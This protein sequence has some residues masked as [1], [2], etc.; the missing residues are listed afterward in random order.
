VGTQTDLPCKHVAVQVSGCNECLSLALLSQGARDTACVQCDQVNDLLR[1]VV[2]LREEVERLRSIRDCENEID[3]WSHTLRQKQQ[4]EA[5]SE[6]DDPLPSC[7]QAEGGDLR[8]K[9]EWSQIPPWRGKRNPSQPPSPSQLP[10]HNRYGA[11][12]IEDNATE[13]G[14]DD[15]TSELPRASHSPPRLRTSSTKKGRKVIVVGDSLLKGTEG[16]ICRPDP[17]H[18]EVICLPGAR[19]KDTQR[20]LPSLVQTSDYYSLLIFQA[21][22]EEVGTRSL[23]VMKND[24]RALGQLVKGSGAQIVFSSILPFARDDEGINRRSKQINSWLRGWCIWQNFGFFDHGLVYRKRGMLATG[25]DRLTCRGRKI[26]G[27]E[28]AGLIHRALN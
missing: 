25:G 24:F 2:E 13:D 16:P 9:G 15:P 23:K 14:E 10:L 22:G 3:W 19:I 7:H 18:R 20:K 6:V 26:L 5:L 28:L 17:S 1:Q 27:Q 11:L 4:E 21:G 12:E 8:D